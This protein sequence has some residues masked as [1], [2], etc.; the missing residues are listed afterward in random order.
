MLFDIG[1][2]IGNWSLSNLNNCDRIIA[3]EAS[4][5]TFNKLKYNLNSNPKIECINYAVSNSGDSFIDFY[6]CQADTISTLNKDWLDS[7]NSRFCK[8]FQYDKISCKTISIDKL[9]EIYGIPEL[10]KIDVE[11]AE[12]EVLS[13]L[14]QKVTNICFEWASELNDI[15]F[16][17]INYLEN[18]G[19][20]EFAIQ[21]GD[22]YVYRPE[23]YQD[24]N[25]IINLLNKTTPKNE[26]GMIWAK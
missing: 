21:Y 11:G 24:K 2:N 12:F 26:W 13:S 22:D 15:T 19:F 1:A 7:E 18:L 14:T 8:Q 4:P 9:I 3:V 16:K 20:T 5:K 6:D 17:S 25:H 23:I 10:I